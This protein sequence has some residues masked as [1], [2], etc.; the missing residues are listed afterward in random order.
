[1]KKV[2]TPTLVAT[3]AAER[4]FPIAEMGVV[5]DRLTAAVIGPDGTVLWLCLPHFD[6]APVFGGLLDRERGGYWRLG[7]ASGASGK[8]CYL[9]DT[10]VLSI[11][12][13]VGREY[14]S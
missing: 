14:L 8:S 7:P 1:M 9:T 13:E 5:G 2:A 11:S 10:N 12:W 4:H 3:R 6:S